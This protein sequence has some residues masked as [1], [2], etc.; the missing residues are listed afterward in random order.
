RCRDTLLREGYHPRQF[1][2]QRRIAVIATSVDTQDIGRLVQDVDLED[3]VLS[4]LEQRET[5]VGGNVPGSQ[6]GAR[7]RF[8]CPALLTRQ[9]DYHRD[10]LVER[11]PETRRIGGRFGCRSATRIASWNRSSASSQ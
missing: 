7:H 8:K 11:P 3:G 1:G 9:T 2:A 6:R 5:A 4:A 10:P